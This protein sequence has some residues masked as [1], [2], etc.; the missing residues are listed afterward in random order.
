MWRLVLVALVACE[1]G[2]SPQDSGFRCPCAEPPANVPP[3]GGSTCGNGVVESCYT[4][5]PMG[6]HCVMIV[7]E[8]CETSTC[9]GLGYYGGPTACSSNCLAVNTALCDACATDNF[10]CKTFE[11][12]SAPQ[13]LATSGSHVAMV[14]TDG[15]L[16][17][18]DGGF[19]VVTAAATMVRDV[20]GVPTGFLA[21]TSTAWF[22]LDTANQAGVSHA[23]PT[24]AADPVVAFGAG[25]NALIAWTQGTM[26]QF[27][28][29]T[30]AGAEVVPSTDL[31]AATTPRAASDGTSFF[32]GAAGSLA[33][34]A[35]DG[36]RTIAAG[37]PTVTGERVY[38]LAGWYVSVVGNSLTAQRFDASGALTGN[39]ITANIGAPILD[40]VADGGDLVV[41]RHASHIELV[42]VD[43]TGA[44]GAA[45]E[46]GVGSSVGELEHMGPNFVVIWG[47]P[48]RV[49][50]ALVAPP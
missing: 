40:I 29:V 34:I 23:L 27:T 13:Q 5:S 43:A 31:F 18:F 4:T 46:V 42:R 32:V 16:E 1:G 15:R 17:L 30:P 8:T 14:D 39:A 44:V 12:T 25:G 3:C 49:E 41:L 21:V 47:R 38:V 6:C 22:H 50:L 36:T 2:S 7:Q 9:E 24:G 19:S 37:F 35:P 45:R 11:S 20:V 48:S 26:T 28:I 10:I 33:R